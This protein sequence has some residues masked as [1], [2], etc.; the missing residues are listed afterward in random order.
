[1]F[2]QVIVVRKDLKIGKGK[3]AAQVAHASLEAYKKANE[4]ARNAWSSEGSKKV[5][6]K[7]KDLNELLSILTKARRLK[8]P[9]SVIRDAGKTQVKSGTITAIGIGPAEEG[10]IDKVTKDLKLL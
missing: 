8:L 4:D 10:K 1:M 2:K 3:I 6:V 5:V 9:C 7:A